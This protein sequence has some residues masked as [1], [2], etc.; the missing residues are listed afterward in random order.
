MF[1]S[2][3]MTFIILADKKSRTLDVF[4]ATCH[5]RIDCSDSRKRHIPAAISLDFSKSISP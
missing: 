4:G 5:L 3:Q 2:T 1:E